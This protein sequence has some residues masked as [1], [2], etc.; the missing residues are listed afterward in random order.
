MVNIM[1]IDLLS[2]SSFFFIMMQIL[3]AR[4]DNLHS[5]T[6]DKFIRDVSYEV[7]KT[8]QFNGE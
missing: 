1:G 5:N 7:S 2:S 8:E 3:I 4:I 6:F